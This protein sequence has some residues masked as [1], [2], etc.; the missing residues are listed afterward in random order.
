MTVPE[1]LSSVE[2]KFSPADFQRIKAAAEFAA[3]AHRGQERAGG[4]P[5]VSHVLATAKTLAELKMDTDTVIAG[6][7]HDVP[8]DT[9]F[10]LADVEQRFGPTVAFLVNG[11]TKLGT[12]KYR[13]LERYVEN[14]RKMF[15]A[16][17]QDVRVMIIKFADRLHNLETL[18]A[19][20]PNKQLR[21][22][23]ESLEILAP[24][25]HRLGMGGIKGQLEDLSFPFV[26]PKEY[27]WIKN[28][29]GHRYEIMTKEIDQMQQTITQELTTAKIHI[30]SIHGRRKHLYSLYRKLL[31]PEYHKDIEK[32]TDLIALRIVVDSISDCYAALGIIHQLWRPVPNRFKD[33]IAQPKPNGYQ[34]LHT[35]VFSPSG[36]PVEIQ[37]RDR[38]MHQSAE[39]GV[40]AHWLYDESG[41]PNAGTAVDPRLA[42]VNQLTAWKQEYSNDEEYLE[43]LKIDALQQRIFCFT[44][45]GEVIDLPVGATPIDFA[46][47]VHSD[48]GNRCA[49]AKINGKM[50]ALNTELRS[51]DQ[52][53]ILVDKNR[54]LPNADWMDFAR[55]QAARSH[56]RKAL[57]EA[58]E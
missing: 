45:K 40:A 33:Y 58:A 39:Y 46:Y 41:K 12:L 13:G 51:G 44:P 56:I 43:A 27:A 55:T 38:S 23:R 25:A 30:D 50:S 18:S 28:L 14:L 3:L 15:L 7:L 2:P 47:H 6:L 5:Y 57:R 10:T 21:I 31:R 53:E 26:Y 24:I 19:L 52:V 42:W 29:V 34:S 11:V 22:A 16:M 37:I 17:A 54:K 36:Q 4:G 32:I 8:E 20:P 35:T 48:L 1:F 9:K 49:G